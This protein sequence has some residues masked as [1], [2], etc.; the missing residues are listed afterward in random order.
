MVVFKSAKNGIL[1]VDDSP[2][3]KP[4]KKMENIEIIFD[5]VEKRYVLGYVHRHPDK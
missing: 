2:L 1:I 3:I 4:G 5:H